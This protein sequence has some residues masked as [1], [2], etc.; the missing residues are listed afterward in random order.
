MDSELIPPKIAHKYVDVEKRVGRKT[1]YDN[2]GCEKLINLKNLKIFGVS[3]ENN[4][5]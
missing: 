3:A 4:G 1:Q 5:Y 2:N